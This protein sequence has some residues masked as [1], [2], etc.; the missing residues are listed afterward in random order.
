MK[1][2]FN[3]FHLFMN[4]TYE[5][6]DIPVSR[7]NKTTFI[8]YLLGAISELLGPCDRFLKLVQH[9]HKV[10]QLGGS[11]SESVIKPTGLGEELVKVRS[12]VPLLLPV[13]LKYTELSSFTVNYNIG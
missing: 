11:P 13:Q 7:K 6:T 5:N 2:K 1:G 4:Y 3:R 8:V 9:V 12:L 10:I